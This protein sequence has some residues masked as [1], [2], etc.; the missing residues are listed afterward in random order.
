MAKG[1]VPDATRVS[2][3]PVVNTGGTHQS[4]LP[5]SD[6]SLRHDD[7]SHIWLVQARGM[8]F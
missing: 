6:G 1:A 2:V 5:I 3:T 7:G 4:M 8:A